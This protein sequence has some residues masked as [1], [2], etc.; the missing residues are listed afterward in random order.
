[1]TQPKNLTRRRLE[2]LVNAAERGLDE[3]SYDIAE[4]TGVPLSGTDEEIR[5]AI[6]D[7]REGDMLGPDYTVEDVRGMV[8]HYR[9]AQEA[10]L[11]LSRRWYPSLY[12]SQGGTQ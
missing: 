1:M 6:A 10:S 9:A 8:D 7:N 12:P 3:L 11:I 4:S 5:Q 2:A